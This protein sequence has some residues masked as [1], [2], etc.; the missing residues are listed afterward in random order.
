MQALL[1]V[2]PGQQD[3][4]RRVQEV[5]RMT[6]H[7]TPVKRTWRTRFAKKVSVERRYHGGDQA[8]PMSVAAI[9]AAIGAKFQRSPGPVPIAVDPHEQDRWAQF[10]DEMHR[11]R[12]HFNFLD[13]TG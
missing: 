13:R 5:T 12:R 3:A 11:K 2:E 10:P 9:A 8:H 6:P 4:L 7:S 1:D